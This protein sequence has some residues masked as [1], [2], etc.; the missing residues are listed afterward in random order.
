MRP[1]GLGTILSASFSLLILLG[2]QTATAVG[3]EQTAIEWTTQRT[4]TSIVTEVN[5]SDWDITN[6]DGENQIAI[7]GAVF[8][9]ETGLPVITKWVFVP[10]GLGIQASIVQQDDFEPTGIQHSGQAGMEPFLEV[11][12]PAVVH[13]IRLF[14]VRWTPVR[15]Q[16]DG[17]MQLARSVEFAAEFNG[18]D[19][20]APGREGT[21]RVSTE[22][23]HFLE[24]HVLNLDEVDI[25]EVTMLGRLLIIADSNTTVREIL[26]PY[27]EWKTQQG[28]TVEI[29]APSSTTSSTAIRNLIQDRYQDDSL[30]PLEYI[31]LV[32]DTDQ[33]ANEPY[34]MAE[35]TNYSD[36]RYSLIEGS[37]YLADAAIGRLSVESSTTL[38]RVVNKILAYERD[39]FMSDTDWLDNVI[40]T[41]GGNESGISP[42]HV[43]QSLQWMFNR[44]GITSDTLW[45]TMPGGD[46]AIPGFIV[47][48]VN[49]GAHFV[50]YRGFNRMSGWSYSDNE[51]FTNGSRLPVFTIITCNTGNFST[52]STCITEG[53]FRAGTGNNVLKGAVA[54]IGT[55]TGNT[56]TRYNNIVDM[57]FYEGALL[58]NIRTVGWSL[59]HAKHRLMETYS[60]TSDYNQCLDFAYWN[61]LMGDPSLR[62][63]FGIPTEPDVTHTDSYSLGTNIVEVSVDADGGIP[64]FAWATLSN[65]NI[66]IDSRRIMADGTANLLID[67]PEEYDTV[68]LTVMG[69]NLVPYQQLLTRADLDVELHIDDVTIDDGQGGDNLANPNENILLEVVVRNSGASTSPAVTATVSTMDTRLAIL[70]DTDIEIPAIVPNG[71]YTI[72]GDIMVQ[73]APWAQDGS[74]PFI[75]LSFPTE[76]ETS[77]A[78]P[79]PITGWTFTNG[80]SPAIEDNDEVIL[81]GETTQLILPIRNVGHMNAEGVQGVLISQNP[82]LTVVDNSAEY[83]TVIEQGV[84]NNTDDLFTITANAGMSV[85][86]RAPLLLVVQD[87]DGAIDSVYFTLLIADPLQLDN[88]V[89]PDRYG[90]WAIDDDDDIPTCEIEPEY[91]WI[92]IGQTENRLTIN[93]TYNE[94]DESSLVDLPFDFTYYGETFDEITVCSNGFLCF[95]SYLDMPFFRNWPIPSAAGPPAMIAPFWDDLRTSGNGNGVYAYY[96]AESHQFIIEWKTL[97]ALSSNTEIFEV[98][99]YD[100]EYYPTNTGNG[101]ILFQYQNITFATNTSSDNDYATI[102]I[103]SPDQTD[104]LMLAWWDEFDDRVSTIGNGSAVLFTDDLGGVPDPPQAAITPES[105]EF[106]LIGDNNVVDTLRISNEAGSTLIWSVI[107]TSGEDQQTQSCIPPVVSNDNPLDEINGGNHQSLKSDSE[108]PGPAQMDDFGGPDAFGYTWRDS[109]EPDGPEFNWHAEYGTLIDDFTPDSDDGISGPYELPFTF[110]YYGEELS[111]LYVST[112]GFLTFLEFD[113]DADYNWRNYALPSSQ[114]PGAILAVWWDDQ[115]ME[116]RGGDVYYWTNNQD[117]VVVTFV[118]M[119]GWSRGG[120]YTY[121]VIITDDH[122]FKYQ[123][124]DMNMPDDD[125]HDESTI[126]FQNSAGNMGLTITYNNADYIEDE[127]AIQ[128]ETPSIWLSVTNASG[129]LEEGESTSVLVHA[130]SLYLDV[131]DY[132]GNLQVNT[133]DPLHSTVNVPVLLHVINGEDG[134]NVFDIPDQEVE[135]GDPFEDIPL[136]QYVYD[137]NYNDNQITWTFAGND[138]LDVVITD[139]VAHISASDNQW[140]GSETITFIAANPENQRDS[141]EVTFTVIEGNAPPTLFSLLAPQDTDTVQQV[142]VTFNWQDSEDPEGGPVTYTL[143]ITTDGDTVDYGPLVS[144]IIP[145]GLDTT[146]LNVAGFQPY[147]WWVIAA[148]NAENYT[149]SADTFG[150]RMYSMDAANGYGIPTEYAI[151]Q[152]YPNPFNPTL[153]LTV[154]LPEASN[155]SVLIYNALGRRVA[156]LG[157][158]DFTAG[159]HTF[160][161]HASNHA[162]GLY[163]VHVR[164]GNG[165]SEVRKVVLMK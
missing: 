7:P 38:R 155:M 81:P 55:A 117:S 130:N 151:T 76:D 11:G 93:D 141:T 110:L 2:I 72:D 30:P 149:A 49:S 73:V 148:D 121:Q 3:Y 84:G 125:R 128:I 32:G 29:E 17:E 51:D 6:R 137:A 60:G 157:E 109:N 9:E 68:M 89:G 20:R 111:E 91:N 78:W 132:A 165:F 71:T 66:L 42:I 12:E 150:F 98:I 46:G 134:P 69:D 100:P 31:L 102:G 43:N 35:Y 104:G 122:T 92:E 83:G 106:V 87:D 58:Q 15:I 24:V 19:D 18:N 5:I 136:D 80:G 145:V 112:N 152:L 153:S 27:A 33:G 82:G 143:Y 75:Q 1:T 113:P 144:S 47:D 161:F 25:E 63:W 135:A 62:M 48:H 139:R 162:S 119:M 50:N 120:P 103:E 147:R 99:L 37:D 59:V 97:S 159:Y 70:S 154:S 158:G 108:I 114:A 39:V 101:R 138:N 34:V 88:L 133:N 8:D 26:E 67:D 45:Y 52:E 105:F 53:I 23:R 57:S 65:G 4:S 22:F 36:Y 16:E 116:D 95:G 90:Y 28:Y 164:A 160:T 131:G 115:D 41:A 54:A 96:D 142:L 129:V 74:E 14:P 118:E 85:G 94:D 13:G 140:I 21:I 10:N 124:L 156:S 163:F 40:L 77:S 126:G 107:A 44:E 79:I 146:G 127:L 123:Y 61:N 64:G 86:E 56:H